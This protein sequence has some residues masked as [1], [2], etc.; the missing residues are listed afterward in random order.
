VSL[1][2]TPPKVNITL[3]RLIDSPLITYVHVGKFNQF[4]RLQEQDREMMTHVEL[5]R[6]FMALRKR[7]ILVSPP[8]IVRRRY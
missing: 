5:V 2:E 7:P 1:E 4:W 6:E 3:S 8:G